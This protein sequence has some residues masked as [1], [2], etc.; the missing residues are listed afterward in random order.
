MSELRASYVTSTPIPD[1]PHM[2]TIVLSDQWVE[3]INML[4]Q[5]RKSDCEAAIV[6]LP[7]LKVGSVISFEAMRK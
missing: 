1:M 6:L 3:V 2:N 7:T 5:L 4:Q